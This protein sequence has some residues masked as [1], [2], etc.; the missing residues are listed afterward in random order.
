[1]FAQA[2]LPMYQPLCQHFFNI[3]SKI[4]RWATPIFLLKIDS[5]S[6]VPFL[7]KVST[8]ASYI[9]RNLHWLRLPDQRYVC[10]YYVCLP[11]QIQIKTK[12]AHNVNL[13]MK[14]GK[15]RPHSHKIK[16]KKKYETKWNVNGSVCNTLAH[17]TLPLYSAARSLRCTHIL[18]SQFTC[19]PTLARSYIRTYLRR[20]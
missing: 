11:Y 15:H 1:M 14:S 2:L 20:S 4:R 17:Y 9:F 7:R 18:H 6:K 13:K 8:D 3:F 16:R 5:K 12:Y 19:T 10:V